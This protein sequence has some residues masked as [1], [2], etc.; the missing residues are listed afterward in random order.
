MIWEQEIIF[1]LIVYLKG[2]QIFLY[3]KLLSF[4]NALGPY[5]EFHSLKSILLSTP[6]FRVTLPTNEQ[7]FYI[8]IAPNKTRLNEI[9]PL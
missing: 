7:E 9:T 6:P 5:V 1:I 4:S 2:S 8:C 3:K